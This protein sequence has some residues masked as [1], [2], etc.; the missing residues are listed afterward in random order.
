MMTLRPAAER[1][2]TSID[3]LESWHSFSFGDYHDPRWRG[4]R[5]LRVINDD[6]V[7]PGGGFDTHPHRDME[8]ITWVLS[9]ALEHRDS[10]GNGSVIRPGDMQRMTAGTGILHSEFNPSAFEGVHLLQI[11]LFPE[12]KG[13][14]PGYEQRAFPRHDLKN[15]LRLVASRDGRNES[16]T[17][18]QDADVY[19]ATLEAGGALAHQ[20]APGRYA[21]LQVA[22]GSVAL[23]GKELQAGDGAAISDERALAVVGRADSEVILFDLA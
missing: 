6:R 5:S 16:V 18:H 2:R 15:A 13:L 4:F 14:T 9:G 11:W 17:I 1:G 20:L 23:N 7:A 22:T 19:A 12:R 10:L 8:I 21:W 3:W